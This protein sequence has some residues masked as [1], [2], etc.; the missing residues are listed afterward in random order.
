M[1]H[2]L[3]CLI[4]VLDQRIPMHSEVHASISQLITPTR[5]TSELHA[6]QGSDHAVG[7]VVLLQTEHPQGVV[8]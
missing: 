4:N 8:S 3:N 2:Q 6:S 5:C 1:Q 7:L